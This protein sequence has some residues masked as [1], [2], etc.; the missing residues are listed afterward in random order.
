LKSLISTFFGHIKTMLSGNGSGI[1]SARV[2]MMAFAI[3][4]IYSLNR[5]F[6]HMILLKDGILL[7]MWMSGLPGIGYLLIGLMAV[8]YTVNKGASSVYDL[9]TTIRGGGNR[10]P[11]DRGPD[12][13][14]QG[15][16]GYQGPDQH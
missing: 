8:P 11:E 5:I 16:Q 1:S 10:P 4:G 15:P 14:S 13:M 7:G 6:T 9:V 12:G 2:L 3:F